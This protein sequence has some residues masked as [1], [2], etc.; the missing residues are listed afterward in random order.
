MLLVNVFNN[1]FEDEI[2]KSFI[3]LSLTDAFKRLSKELKIT[4]KD[5]LR[6]YKIID[7][8]SEMT[9]FNQS[10]THRSIVFNIKYARAS[11]YRTKLN[12]L[13]KNARVYS[14]EDKRDY[15]STYDR[16]NSYIDNIYNA[17][18]AMIC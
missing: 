7:I 4:C 18:H 2:E 9:L 6:S 11:I 15:I 14:H 17:R 13:V 1:V 8:E 5:K 10:L 16:L 3:C 12:H